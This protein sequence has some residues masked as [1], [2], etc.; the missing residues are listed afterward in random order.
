MSSHY[1]LIAI[2]AGSGGLSVANRAASYGAR[3]A[4]V[5]QDVQLGGTC[6][7][8][9][10]VPK[11]VMWYG[12]GIAQSLKDAQGYGFDLTQNGFD[13]S[14]LVARREEYIRGINEWYHSYLSDPKVDTYS[15][16]ARVSGANTV[17]VGDVELTADRIVLAPGGTPVV[18]D[19][20]GAELGITSDGFFELTEQPRKVAVIGAGYIAI[21]LA[22][23]LHGLGSDVS[24]V[25]RH[26]RFLREFD[27]LISDTLF[28]AM[29]EDGVNI[30]GEFTPAA[31][32]RAE[33]GTIAVVSDKAVRQEGFDAVIFA[34]GRRPATSDLGLETVGLE[35]D[36]R[37]YIAVDKF[38]ETQVSGI[39]ALGDVTGQAELTPVAIA[40][41]RRMADRLYNDQTGR[42]LSYELIPTVIFSH[43]PAGTIGLSERQAREQYGDS[44][45]VYTTQFTP[46]YSVFS[47]HT[48]PT[49]MKLVVTGP[50]ERI[51]GCHL[52]GIGVDEMLQGFAVAIRMGATKKDFDDTVAI[53]PSSAEELVT[54]R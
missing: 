3:C 45:K 47:D 2:G 23:V 21:E 52:V 44:V 38:Q 37:G 51:V 34:I 30:V 14:K 28:E 1:D 16:H 10:C 26:G 27:D 6:V 53:H 54:M 19:I 11:K 43:P 12:S 9:G 5:E 13:W 41:G 7:N 33:D 22:G 35:T 20:P 40:A 25:I 4:I 39:Y 29:S 48:T 32:E 15:G 24:L 17:S 8:R 36:S 42:H 46:M 18:P 50:D 49:A 31:L